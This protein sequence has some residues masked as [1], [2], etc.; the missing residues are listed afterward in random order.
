MSGLPLRSKRLAMAAVGVAA[1]A[2]VGVAVAAGFGAFNES[3]PFNGIGAAQHRSTAADKLDLPS[4]P[5][6]RRISDTMLASCASFLNWE[7]AFASMPS[8]RRGAGCAPSPRD[9]RAPTL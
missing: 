8:Q 3:S 7:A 2:G 5:P 6:L 4:R 9:C 1:L